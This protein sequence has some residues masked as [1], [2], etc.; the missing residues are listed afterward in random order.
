MI[1]V[2]IEGSIVISTIVHLNFGV[3][4]DDTWDMP[5]DRQRNMSKRCTVAHK[6]GTLWSLGPFHLQFSVFGGFVEK[7]SGQGF[8]F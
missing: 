2:I 8:H 5:I 7:C 4:S 1:S 6:W 3:L